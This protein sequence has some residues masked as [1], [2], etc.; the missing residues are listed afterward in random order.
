[1]T[2]PDQGTPVGHRDVTTSNNARTGHCHTA[3]ASDVAGYGSSGITGPMFTG[4]MAPQTASHMA[5]QPVYSPMAGYAMQENGAAWMT[6]QQG[7]QTEQPAQINSIGLQQQQ[8]HQQQQHQQPAGNRPAGL[9]SSN[10][11]SHFPSQIPA[12]P[13]TPSIAS[14]PSYMLSPGYSA[15][16]SSL[17][18][19]P[20]TEQAF[21]QEQQFQSDTQQ[22]MQIAQDQAMQLESSNG[23]AMQGNYG[24][25]TNPDH[26]MM[27]MAAAINAQQQQM[28]AMMPQQTINGQQ[29]ALT[30]GPEPVPAW[31]A[32]HS[33]SF[34]YPQ[35]GYE[36]ARNP[37][38][39]Y[40]QPM[41]VSANNSFSGA[42]QQPPAY[43]SGIPDSGG[44]ANIEHSL[45]QQ[46]PQQQHTTDRKSVV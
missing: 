21:V 40:M 35:F 30:S 10:W 33:Q 36:N 12:G 20:G 2:M 27:S 37:P 28:Q 5:H 24:F 38:M 15:N 22:A 26:Q 42:V 1:M 13:T 34:Y 44:V 8:H 31:L 39:G 29:S 17:A 4:F 43:I 11:L 14:G 16:S 23:V 9:A 46:P 25:M 18:G 6:A 45:V 7:M 3:A 41:P 32:S 19:T